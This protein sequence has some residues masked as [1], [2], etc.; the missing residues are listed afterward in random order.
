MPRTDEQKQKDKDSAMVKKP[1]EKMESIFN[2][3][4]LGVQANFAKERLVIMKAIEEQNH[5]LA[6]EI[7]NGLKVPT[8]YK[9]AMLQIL[10]EFKKL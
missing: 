3:L 2:T 10:E 9:P 1:V 5:A 7:F 4:P 8:D 6:L